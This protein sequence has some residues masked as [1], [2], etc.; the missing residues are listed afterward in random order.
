MKPQVRVRFAPSPTGFLHLGGMRSAL[1]NWL[2]ARQQKGVFILRIEDTDRERLVEGAVEQILASHQWLGLTPDETA[3]QSERV[4]TYQKNADQL[5]AK[6]VLYPCWCTPER[7]DKLRK[8]AQAN[9]TAFKYDRYCLDHPGDPKKPHVLRFMIPDKPAIISWNDAVRGKM[10]FPIETQDDFVSLKSDGWPTY[11]F[12]NVVDDHLMEITHVLRAEEFLPSTPKHIL[13]YQAFGWDQPTFAHLPQVL[14]SDGAKLSKRHGAKSV[15]EYRDEGYLPEAIINFLAGLGW[16]QGEGSTKEIYTPDELVQA[17]TL[18]R[19]QKSPAVFDPQRLLWLNG[20]YIRS[21]S[22]KQ[23]L[24][25]SGPFWPKEAAKTETAYKEAILGLVQERMKTLAELPELTDFFFTE[26]KPN[27]EGDEVGE[28]LRQSLALVNKTSVK[29]DDLEAAFRSLAA[30]LSASPKQF[31]GALRL[32][33]TGK[34]A[35]PPLFETMAVLGQKTV[36]SR[37]EKAISR[38]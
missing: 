23:L 1:F 12:A 24:K 33:I 27:L 5:L 10:E 16:N 29:P 26:P 15:L 32:A 34:S 13:L 11:N 14:G 8:Q 6:G 9:H 21:L 30:K 20:V 37:L 38:L 18:A 7:L 4:E 25:I 31:F 28:W 3:T 19:I 35:T 17:F 36:V 22:V 2:F